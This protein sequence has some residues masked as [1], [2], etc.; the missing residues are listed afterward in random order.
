LNEVQR[1]HSRQQGG[2]LVCEW[3]LVGLSLSKECYATFAKWLVWSF[4]VRCHGSLFW[5]FDAPYAE[6]SFLGAAQEFGIEWKSIPLSAPI[7]RQEPSKLKVATRRL[8]PL[9]SWGATSNDSTDDSSCSSSSASS[10]D[11]SDSGSSEEQNS[12]GDTSA[13][14]SVD[15]PT[16]WDSIV[17]RHGMQ[18]DSS[19]HALPPMPERMY[20]NTSS[21]ADSLRHVKPS[22]EKRGTPGGDAS[23][24]PR[25]LPERTVS[26]H[27][28][29]KSNQLLVTRTRSQTD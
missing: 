6:W 16:R 8:M 1:F 2:V 20:T 23:R 22:L 13:G 18:L 9:W 29:S 12:D 19:L 27:L 21:S 24:F 4:G 7:L 10:D 11:F 28:G 15:S 14:G 17:K 5:N 3:S 26:F 25:Q